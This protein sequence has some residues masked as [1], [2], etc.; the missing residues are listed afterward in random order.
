MSEPAQ[1][2]AQDDLAVKKRG[3]EQKLQRVA[4]L[5]LG[6]GTRQVSRCNGDDESGL[7][8]ERR[9]NEI[10]GK[11]A[12]L[13]HRQPWPFAKERSKLREMPGKALVKEENQTGEQKKSVG[14]AQKCCPPAP[15]QARQIEPEK[16]PNQAERALAHRE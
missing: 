9:H 16:R 7:E 12:P 8:R 6:H 13:L 3:R 11:L 10:P 15:R 4:F 1:Q 2:L 5:L 14:G